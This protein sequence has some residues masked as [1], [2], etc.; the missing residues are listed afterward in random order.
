M[1]Y[2]W[3]IVALLLIALGALGWLWRVGLAQGRIDWGSSWMNAL[4]GLNRIFCRCYHRSNA[5]AIH[6]PERGGAIVASNHISGLDPL[7]LIAASTRPLR[8]MIAREEYE[9]FGL[10]WLF[11]A[12]GCIPVDRGLR[13]GRALRE[14][15]RALHRGEVIAIFPHGGIYTAEDPGT[16]K[17]GIVRLAKKSQCLIYPVHIDGVRGAGH[18]LPAVLLRSRVKLHVF[19]ALSCADVEHPACLHLLAKLLHKKLWG[20]LD[21]N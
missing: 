11:R 8:F 16:L 20:E 12:A 5:A 4:D 3:M 21:N 7:L 19:P 9:R 15:L 10:R 2:E 13:P 18:T 1:R 14:A 17:G 6:L